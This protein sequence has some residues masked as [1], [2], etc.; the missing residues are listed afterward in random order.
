MPP[1]EHDE[2]LPGALDDVQDQP[3]I[4]L[5]DPRDVIML[6]THRLRPRL[7]I[8]ADPIETRLTMR[9]DYGIDGRQFDGWEEVAGG[10][11]GVG[12]HWP[13]A[14]CAQLAKWVKIA[15]LDAPN[16]TIRDQV[17]YS[18]LCELHWMN[19]GEIPEVQPLDNPTSPEEAPPEYEQEQTTIT[20]PRWWTA[21]PANTTHDNMVVNVEFP[22][23]DYQR[24]ELPP[25]LN[26]EWGPAADATT[27]EG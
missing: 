19:R 18:A 10:P 14:Y 7:R 24:I 6:H 5:T 3:G 11:T 20:P 27:G 4:P 2:A 13:F 16:R 17:V 1:N 21:L 12:C 15:W 23:G 9:A 26:P 22:P 25:L 8:T